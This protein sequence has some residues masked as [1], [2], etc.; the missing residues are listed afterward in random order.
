MLIKYIKSEFFYFVS[1]NLFS[2]SKC[3]HCKT[4]ATQKYIQIWGEKPDFLFYLS[5][6]R[7]VEQ[8]L[9]IEN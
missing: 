1:S 8:V 3:Y 4:I 7:R 2:S 5:Q 6:G 9:L